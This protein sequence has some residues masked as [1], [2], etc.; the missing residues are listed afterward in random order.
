MK[1]ILITTFTATLLILG[2]GI[3]A[4]QTTESNRTIISIETD[5]ST[6]LLKGYALHLR[7]KPAKSAHFQLGA[8]IYA[9]D[10]P[11]LM[12]N[13]NSA[14]KDKGWSLRLK[15][16]YALFGEYYFKEG[17]EKW[18]TGLQAGVQ[19]YKI[20]NATA[21]G[22]S[23]SYS[24]F[25]LMPSVGYNWHPFKVPFY[26]KPWAGLGYTAKVSGNNSIEGTEYKI[27]PIIPFVTVH[28][29]YTFGR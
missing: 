22:K 17:G 24:N 13:M 19:N 1:T 18:F 21:S 23:S 5:P 12:I 27:A 8:G 3:Q 26:V 15:S 29:G 14:N 11:S 10:F 4:Q 20:T 16:A 6:F 7:V 9:L 25:L 2:K 28:A